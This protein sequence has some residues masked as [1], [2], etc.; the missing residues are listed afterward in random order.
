MYMGGGG[1]LSEK[2]VQ[3]CQNAGATLAS[4]K[5]TLERTHARPHCLW[6]NI[7]AR[8]IKKLVTR[9]TKK[10]FCYQHLGGKNLTADSTD[11]SEG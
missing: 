3:F 11:N 1:L 6:P 10:M 4:T 9:K 5:V 2:L 7:F 8:L